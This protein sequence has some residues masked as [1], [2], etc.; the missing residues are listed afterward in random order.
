MESRIQKPVSR[1]RNETTLPQ[2]SSVYRIILNS[3][4]WILDS[5]P[6]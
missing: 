4:F 3:E 1:K 2:S 6:L 5:F